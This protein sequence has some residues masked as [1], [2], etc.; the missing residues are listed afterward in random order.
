VLGDGDIATKLD[1][2]VT[3]PSLGALAAPQV[4]GLQ[5]IG[6]VPIYSS[7]PLV[8]RSPPL[9]KTRDAEPPVAWLSAADYSS[10]GLAEGDFLRVRQEG[11]EAIV[12]VAVDK[13]LPAGCVRLAA[14]RPET[15]RLGSMIGTVSVERVAGQQKVAV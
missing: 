2:R 1:N 11:G 9:Q 8:R 3:L 7:D 12:A 14:A 6:E 13:G 5:R 15:A 4:D 10:L